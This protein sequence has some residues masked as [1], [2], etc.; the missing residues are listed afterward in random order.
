MGGL[1]PPLPVLRDNCRGKSHRA[2]SGGLRSEFKQLALGLLGWQGAMSNCR[3]L[4]GGWGRGG[5]TA[6]WG[7]GAAAGGHA[8]DRLRT[9]QKSAMFRTL[10]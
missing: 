8:R 7:S 10:L 9:W 1:G 2:G 5:G 4:L 6:L 3:V